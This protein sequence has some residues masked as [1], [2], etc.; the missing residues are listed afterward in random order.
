MVDSPDPGRLPSTT[1]ISMDGARRRAALARQR[2]LLGSLA[3]TPGFRI[4]V[5]WQGAEGVSGDFYDTWMMPDGRIQVALGDVCGHGVGAALVMASLLKTLRLRRS[6][7]A[8]PVALLAAL[9]ADLSQDLSPGDFATLWLAELA[10]GGAGAAAAA[11]HHRAFLVRSDGVERVGGTGPALGIAP[12]VH[13]RSETFALGQGDWLVQCSDGLFEML[14]PDGEPFGEERLAA[15]LL[16]LHRTGLPVEAAPDALLAEAGAWSGAPAAD[17]LTIVALALDG[18]SGEHPGEDSSGSR[19]A[20]GWRLPDRRASTDPG[21]DYRLGPAI[22]SGGNG[23]VHEAVQEGLGRGVA[24]KRAGQ[25]AQAGGLMREGLI[26]AALEH[27]NILPVHEAGRDP[28][29]GP[30]LAM[31]RPAGRTWRAQIP[32]L[33]LDRNLDVLLAVADAVASAH[34]RGIIHRDIKPDNVLLGDDGAVYLFDWGVAAAADGLDSAL[35]AVVRRPR[36]GQ[37]A[38]SP[39]YMAPEMARGEAARIGTASDVYLLGATLHELLTGS[40]LHA[41][42][43]VDEALA[44]A[45]E[46][47]QP[48]ADPDEP[49]TS[50]VVAACAP[51]PAD[52]P[53][54]ARAFRYLLA[55]R[56]RDRQALIMALEAVRR[57]EAA[58]DHLSEHLRALAVV[59]EALRLCPDDAG[60][61]N[62]VARVRAAYARPALAQG[63]LALATSLIDPALPLH[64]DLARALTH[65]VEARRREADRRGELEDLGRRTEPAWQLLL[66]GFSTDWL[67]VG[68]SVVVTGRNVW[69]ANHPIACVKAPVICT[70]DVRITARLRGGTHPHARVGCYIGASLV[71]NSRH[72]PGDGYVA[73]IGADG[74]SLLRGAEPVAHAARA[75]TPGTVVQIELTRQ[76]S[77]VMVTIDGRRAITWSDAGGPVRPGAT[78]SGSSARMDRSRS[79][80]ARS[81]VS[82]CRNSRTPCSSPNATCSPVATRR[83]WTSSMTWWPGRRANGPNGRR[84]CAP[85]RRPTRPWRARC[86]TRRWPWRRP[87]PGP[88]LRWLAASST[89]GSTR[90]QATSGR[91]ADW[92]WVRSNAWSTGRSPTSLRSAACHCSGCSSP[93]SG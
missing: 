87:S 81:G 91:S 76:G 70:D 66:Q 72:A 59:E 6:T 40:L 24:I 80:N 22:A 68:N 28:E 92:P 27:P 57:S 82:D 36:D 42:T 9:D 8:G 7:V 61:R 67:P 29:L 33:G 39:A 53:Q 19:R 26:A 78:G 30:F 50:V 38:G 65:A 58:G 32:A 74:C 18:V 31:R 35:A 45:A 55:A 11:G 90:R 60:V 49:L 3:Q 46:G 75:I 41:G 43:D 16:A 13:H 52:R 17:D 14:G 1:T 51:D 15:T 89:C 64:S 37:A 88:P 10:P 25:A 23:V 93:I 83:R 84:R 12:G 20:A 73:L 85:R 54:D 2:R 77:V 47:R 21:G 71:D 86:K 62:A 79:W 5:R 48:V 4:G 63:D 56:R 34:R 69:A 44:N